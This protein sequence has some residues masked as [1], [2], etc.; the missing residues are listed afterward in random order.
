MTEPR[1]GNEPS[2]ERFRDLADLLL[3][4]E[5]ASSLGGVREACD[6]VFALRGTHDWP[7]VLDPPASWEQPF[8][9]LADE[10]ELSVSNLD[11]AVEEARAFIDAIDAATSS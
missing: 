8:G 6:E 9:R 1:R 4:R 10:L 11:Q 7:P 5:L 2:N 3:L